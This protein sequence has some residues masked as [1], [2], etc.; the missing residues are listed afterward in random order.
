MKSGFN[1]INE[2][3]FI[4]IPEKYDGSI[5]LDAKPSKECEDYHKNSCIQINISD[6]TIL[7]KVL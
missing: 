5:A 4:Y 6:K 1:K 3:S 2:N 7:K